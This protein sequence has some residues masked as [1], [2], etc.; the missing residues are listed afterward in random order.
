LKIRIVSISFIAILFSTIFPSV[1][2]VTVKIANGKETTIGSQPGQNT[3]RVNSFSYNGVLN[4]SNNNRTSADPQIDI[5]GNNTYVVWSDDSPGNPDIFF[6][7]STDGGNTF[8]DKPINLSNNSGL[9]SNPVLSV[10]G[11]N[12]CVVWHD[13]TYKSFDI[14]F[15]TSAD[16]GN[17]FSKPIKLTQS[18]NNII[19]DS[20]FPSIASFENNVY[21]VWQENSTGFFDVLLKKSTDGGNTFSDKPIN[22]SN[23]SGNSAYPKIALYGNTSYVVWEDNSTGNFDILLKKSTDGGNT[24]SDKPINLSKNKGNSSDPKVFSDEKNDIFVV[25]DDDSPG[26][27][28]I[29]FTK[30]TDGGETFS[31][32]VNLSNNTR[33]SFD[34]TLTISKNHISVAWDDDSPGNADILFTKSTDRGDSFSIKPINLSKNVGRSLYPDVAISRSNN[35]YII[36]SDD[37]P[38]NYEVF[39]LRNVQ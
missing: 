7:K 14:F 23:N 28:D 35:S 12:V 6:T 16:G 24:F 3:T 8:S 36:W 10:R 38:G 13:D 15:A 32:P 30:S 34:P 22:L 1:W 4:V 9:S 39:L 31:R 25:W 18:A 2:I 20:E 21:L 27:A 5:S 19:V 33:G 29:F 17:T 26:N 11:S 37:T